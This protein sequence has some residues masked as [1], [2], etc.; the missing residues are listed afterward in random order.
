MDPTIALLVRQNSA[1]TAFEMHAKSLIKASEDNIADI[2]SQ[3]RDL[4]RL[5]ERER[6]IIAMLRSAIVP[7]NKLSAELL[8]EIFL[9]V[10]MPGEKTSSVAGTLTVSQVSAYWRKIAVTTPRLWTNFLRLDVK[11]KPT[12]AYLQILKLWLDRSSP[13]PIPISVTSSLPSD[14]IAPLMETLTSGANRWGD[15]TLKVKSLASL[16]AVAPCALEKLTSIHFWMPP[17]PGTSA[18][19]MF[20]NALGLRKATL[21]QSDL[22][23][24]PWKQLTELTMAIE[25]SSEPTKCLK[26][27]KHCANLLRLNLR[28]YNIPRESEVIPDLS[29]IV[30]PHLATI[31]LTKPSPLFLQH[32]TLPGLRELFLDDLPDSESEWPLT[33]TQFQRRSPVITHLFI[34]GSQMTSAQLATVLRNSPLVQ[35]L[36]LGRCHHSIDAFLDALRY[37]DSD[38]SLLAP[39]LDE[40]W[41]QVSANSF[42]ESCLEQ[43]IRSRWWTEGKLNSI[44]PDRRPRVKRWEYIR[45]D[46]QGTACRPFIDSFKARVEDLRLQGLNL[47]F[48]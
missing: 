35:R 5:R 1:S 24:L 13:L 25:T 10:S 41:L 33:F 48:R 17:E 31:Q 32:L 27:L 21:Y 23:L 40:L 28:W 26:I 36:V 37:R 16:P 18:S 15:L 6:G 9:L 38:S 3:M 30:L 19:T 44:P 39:D 34:Y 42:S 22:V 11:V 7:V 12:D 4:A 43:T 14:D 45:L 29:P 46:I 8:V 2:D 20:L 47:T